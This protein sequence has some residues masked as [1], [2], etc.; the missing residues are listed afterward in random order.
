MQCLL[1]KIST[2]TVMEYVK[3]NRTWQNT[4]LLF[5]LYT[6]KRISYTSY[7]Q[8]RVSVKMCVW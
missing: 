6:Q 7:F 2:N 1:D 5:F 3:Q 8:A 4:A